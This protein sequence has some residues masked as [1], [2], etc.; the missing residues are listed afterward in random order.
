MIDSMEIRL[1][2]NDLYVQMRK[3]IWD[4]ETVECLADLEVSCYSVF[5]N[6]D[7][8]RMNLHKL[9]SFIYDIRHDDEELDNAMIAFEEALEDAENVFVKL[10]FVNEVS[11]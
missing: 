2:Y 3:Y 11:S 4:Y 6:L 7:D 1:L 9:N 10:D 5:Q 8:V